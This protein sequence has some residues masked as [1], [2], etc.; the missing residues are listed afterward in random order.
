MVI[1]YNSTGDIL[2][3][4]NFN[5]PMNVRSG[6]NYLE[7]DNF[8]PVPTK[9]VDIMTGNVVIA[10]QTIS[11]A[12]A[13]ANSTTAWDNLRAQR[14]ALIAVTDWVMLPDAK[15]SEELKANVMTYRQ[16]LRDITNTAAAADTITFPMSPLVESEF[17][18][19][20]GFTFGE[21]TD[22]AT[23]NSTTTP[24]N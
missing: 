23:S 5:G 13:T 15:L 16:T 2:R 10:S 6:E 7:V 22:T 9:R 20:Y 8:S 18:K 17:A 11:D 4:G 19:R 14:D 1:I 24:S 12:A 3:Y 21:R